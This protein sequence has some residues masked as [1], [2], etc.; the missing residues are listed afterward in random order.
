VTNVITG[1]IAAILLVIFLGEY[2]THIKS[3]PLGIIIVGTLLL[4]LYDYYDSVKRKNK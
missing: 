1:A 3:I 4:L 2:A